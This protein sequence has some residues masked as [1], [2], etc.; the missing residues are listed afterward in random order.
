LMMMSPN[1]ANGTGRDVTF[2][3]PLF[4]GHI[5]LM[6]LLLFTSPSTLYAAWRLS[7]GHHRKC[8]QINVPAQRGT[9]DEA[10]SSSPPLADPYLPNK[11][12]FGPLKNRP[13]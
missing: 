13:N 9:V 12:A 5:R 4:A 8:P 2:W 10:K 7:R 1:L 6:G 11:L 3:P